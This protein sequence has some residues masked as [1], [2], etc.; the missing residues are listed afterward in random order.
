MK[1]PLHTSAAKV[2]P[3]I[4]IASSLAACGGGSDPQTGKA[5][6]LAAE[7]STGTA[8]TTA[9]GTSAAI[10]GVLTDVRFENTNPQLAQ[11][12]VPVTFGQVF[13]QGALSPADGLVGRLSDGT[14]IALQVDVKALHADGSVRHAVISAV[15]PSLAAGQTN[16]MSLV[17]SGTAASAG[18]STPDD[19]LGAGFSASVHATINGVRYEAF[20]DDLLKEGPYQTW[21]SGPVASE[22]Q[23]S[24]P[25]T[26]ADGTRHPHLSARF[27]IR[28]YPGASKARVDVTVEN[29]WAYEPNPQNITYDASVLVGAKEVY[30]K[31]G[32]N[33]LNHA[34]WRKVFW[35]NG[36]APEVN[37]KHNAAY[38][39][40]TRAL[41]NY[42]QTVT[43]PETKLAAL[44][45]KW[46]GAITEPMGIGLATAY[47]PQ[48]GG[49]DDI[50]L[51]PGWAA[52]WLL[53]MDKR[54][55]D[56]TLGT[57]DG[58][59]SWSA[60]YRDKNTGR[61]VSLIDYPY[62]TILGRIGD[63]YN[64]VTRKYEAFPA[65]ASSTACT[66]P[67][68]HDSA[69]MPNLAY[70]PYL[71][72][73]DYY[74]LEELQFWA[75]WAAF[76]S[77][78]GY[79]QN[80]KG[81]VLADQ[82]R[83][84]AWTMRTVAE[85]AYITPDNDRLKAHFTQIVNSNL[86]WFNQTY[87]NNAAANQLGIIVNGYSLVYN[88]GTGMAPWQ[89]DFFTSAIGHAAELG[90]TKAQPLLAWK[91]K[92]PVSR[93]T[94][95]G[96]CWVDG[97]IYTLI[98][99]DSSTSP[100][101]ATMGQAYKTSHTATFNALSCASAE[102]ATALKLKVGEMTG[103]SAEA[104]GYPSNLQPALAYAADALGA[105]GKSAWTVFMNRSVKPNYGLAPQF[106]IVPR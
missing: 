17:K 80:V 67:Y 29:D 41:P 21:L 89:D 27:A 45:A 50:G 51:L 95:D 24:A 84:Q 9:S 103:Y 92:F 65:C 86:D 71:L 74:Y 12:N 2:L 90:F 4:F 54:A 15:L 40:A 30:A 102:M 82:V 98:V 32:L 56:V 72:T 76:S 43:I 1:F 105:P 26:A 66:T 61:P 69:H 57:A 39:I 20:A 78:P 37:V 35:Y 104:T 14:T 7:L 68:T 88:N 60:H 81:L 91:S 79:R 59:G 85:A 11:A 38:L 62:M 47:M 83:G 97:S 99:R 22:W 16:A 25:L 28:W 75:M 55:R 49:R 6:V 93:M 3:A 19:L 77:N 31:T 106:A 64:P 8:T 36:T 52:T 5:T 44:Q 101:Y 94:A 13:A 42:D 18:A 87:T 10:Q 46:T 73:G 53:S 34:R 23:V 48:T 63:T 100:Y 96:A 58:A 70:L 33:H